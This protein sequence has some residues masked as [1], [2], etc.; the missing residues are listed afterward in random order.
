M[1][2]GDVR[3]N[4]LM[5]LGGEAE[6]A[7]LIARITRKSWDTL[8]FLAGDEAVALVKSVALAEGG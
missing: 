1:A 3:V 2:L 6:G 7:H 4:V 8:G 5:R